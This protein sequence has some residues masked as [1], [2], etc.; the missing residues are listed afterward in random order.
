MPPTPRPGDSEGQGSLA[1]C[2]PL[3]RKESGMT[4]L[5]ISRVKQWESHPCEWKL[6]EKSRTIKARSLVPGHTTYLSFSKSGDLPDRT[7]ADRFLGGQMGVTS[8][9]VL[10]RVFFVK[11]HLGQEMPMHTVK[12]LEIYQ[13]GTVNEASSQ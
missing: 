8:M 10:P 9:D 2:S 11:I 5:L 13:I 12:D 1:C 3:G 6:Q 7:H 4:K